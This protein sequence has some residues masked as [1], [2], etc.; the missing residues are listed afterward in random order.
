MTERIGQMRRSAIG[1]Q[2]GLTRG[3]VRC[4]DGALLN[5]SATILVIPSN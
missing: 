2:L 4:D 5:R 1:R 3:V